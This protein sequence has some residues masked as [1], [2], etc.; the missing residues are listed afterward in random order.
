MPDYRGVFLRGY[1]SQAHSQLNGSA[2]GVT[3]TLHQSGPLGQVQGDAIRPLSGNFSI[4]DEWMNNS[5]K[6]NGAFAYGGA[7]TGSTDTRGGAYATAYI[8]FNVSRI[9][10]TDYEIRPANTS[11]RYLIRAAQ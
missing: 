10:P 1:G 8:N 6:Q 4:S 5:S 9:A 11:V 2:V 3:S 7:R